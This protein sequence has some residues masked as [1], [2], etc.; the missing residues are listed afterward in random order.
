MTE[1]VLDLERLV[2]ALDAAVVTR[3]EIARLRDVIAGMETRRVMDERA[4]AE[5]VGELLGLLD[6]E[7]PMWKQPTESGY[8]PGIDFCSCWDIPRSDCCYCGYEAR[9]EAKRDTRIGTR[10][11]DL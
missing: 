10:V 6:H 2:N 9:L 8:M 1:G 11:V 7:H 4:H 3:A 5:A